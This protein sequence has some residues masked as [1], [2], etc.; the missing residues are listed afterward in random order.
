MKYILA[1][2]LSVSVSTAQAGFFDFVE[3]AFSKTGIFHKKG[4]GHDRGSFDFDGP[5]F[6]PPPMMEIPPNGFGENPL[7]DVKDD[8]MPAVPVP[9]AVWLFLSGLIGLVCVARKKNG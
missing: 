5:I 8:P 7:D 4:N 6:P 2:I 1:I 9:A 3:D